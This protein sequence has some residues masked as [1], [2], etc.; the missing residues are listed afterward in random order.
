M[1]V[2]QGY[3]TWSMLFIE[4][5]KPGFYCASGHG[6]VCGLGLKTLSHNQSFLNVQ[7]VGIRG[8]Y[9]QS[10]YNQS[11]VLS[12][13]FSLV[14]NDL[15]IGSTSSHRA[16]RVAPPCFYSGSEGTNQTMAPEKGRLPRGK[17]SWSESITSQLEFSNSTKQG[18]FVTNLQNWL[19]T[20][21]IQ[22][23]SPMQSNH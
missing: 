20:K 8:M 22:P 1:R 6:E 14:Y 19:A 7:C 23:A 10:E 15:Y 17:F 9:R 3:Y 4:D 13:M 18:L 5:D 12:I 21:R 2:K 16:L 11:M